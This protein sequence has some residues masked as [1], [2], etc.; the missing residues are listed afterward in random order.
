[1]PQRAG[2]SSLWSHRAHIPGTGQIQKQTTVS[3]EPVLGPMM[4]ACAKTCG[5]EVGV[6][7]GASTGNARGRVCEPLQ[8]GCRRGSPSDASTLLASAGHALPPREGPLFLGAQGA[9]RLL[10]SKDT[11]GSGNA[12]KKPPS[13][14]AQARTRQ[15]AKSGAGNHPHGEGRL[16]MA[17]PSPTCPVPAEGSLGGGNQREGGQATACCVLA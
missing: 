2:S 11:K 1:M 15:R 6:G 10:G 14:K 17:A 13:L 9:P 5:E 4:G 3:T 7:K 12:C 8:P 16:G